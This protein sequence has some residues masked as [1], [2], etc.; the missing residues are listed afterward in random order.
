MHGWAALLAV[1]PSR[2]LVGNN[3]SLNNKI[4]CILL[5]VLE[6]GVE[7]TALYAGSEELGLSNRVGCSQHIE[8]NNISGIGSDVVRL[9]EE[10]LLCAV[11]EGT[12]IHMEG[13]L[14]AGGRCSHCSGIA[15]NSLGR[16][17]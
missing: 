1:E 17:G 5:V 12:N 14:R 7:R 4:R 3:E 8:E 16:H 15:R 11:L 13:L 9:E 10:V 2:V 6:L